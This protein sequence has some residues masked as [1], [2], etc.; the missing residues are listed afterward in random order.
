MGKSPRKITCCTHLNV[1]NIIPKCI[2]GMISIKERNNEIWKTPITMDDTEK[3]EKS[4]FLTQ[5]SGN[6]KWQ[7]TYSTY[8][9]HGT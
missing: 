3:E 9:G 2:N 5:R 6:Q 4:Y 1:T 7:M 8:T